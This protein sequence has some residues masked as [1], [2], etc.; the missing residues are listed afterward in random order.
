MKEIT[1]KQID[2]AI[3]NCYWRKD[4]GGVPVCTGDLIPCH[5]CIELGKCDTLR[6]LFEGNTE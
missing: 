5:R 4:I 3:K 6:K 2:G 1:Q